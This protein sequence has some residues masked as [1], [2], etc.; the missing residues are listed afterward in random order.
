MLK[1]QSCF[2]VLST[3]EEPIGGW[4]D[5]MY[6]PNGVCAA[7]I[8]GLLRTMHC[9]KNIHANIVPV[10]KSAAGIIAAAWDVCEKKCDG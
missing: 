2:S 5:N 8:A 3:Y 9:N 10:D 6:G 4:I 7:I 1:F